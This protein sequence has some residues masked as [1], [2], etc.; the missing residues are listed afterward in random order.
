MCDMLRI[1]SNGRLELTNGNLVGS[2][3]N[4][5]CYPGFVLEGN[6]KRSCQANMEWTGTDPYC[7]GK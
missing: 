5:F 4:Y 7:R 1:P 2:T 6:S 3:A